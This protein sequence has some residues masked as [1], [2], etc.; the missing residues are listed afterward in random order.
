MLLTVAEL[1]ARLPSE[2]SL[3]EATAKHHLNHA[4]SVH[5]CFNGSAVGGVAVLFW[6][7]WSDSCS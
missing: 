6:Q 5:N 2:Q 1:G 3:V 7:R 4:L